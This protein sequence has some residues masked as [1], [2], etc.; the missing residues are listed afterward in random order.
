MGEEE[1]KWRDISRVPQ[2]SVLSH[3]LFV[4]YINYLPDSI[5]NVFE[6][7]SDDSK[8]IAELEDGSD[9]SFTGEHK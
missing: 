2:W 4:I 5:F 3:L 8:V 9:S 7:Y 1:S 6:M